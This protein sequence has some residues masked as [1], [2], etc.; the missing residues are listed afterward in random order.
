M[1][2]AEES[3]WVNRKGGKASGYFGRVGG[4]VGINL[5]LSC[6]RLAGLEE[7]LPSSAF[8]RWEGSVEGAG[9]TFAIQEVRRIESVLTVPSRLS[10]N[11][12]TESWAIRVDWRRSKPSI[13]QDPLANGSAPASF[14]QIVP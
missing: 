3:R 14:F 13:S 8:R 9:S 1:D 5:G 2:Y 12:M 10:W 11:C 6:C 7:E 4:G